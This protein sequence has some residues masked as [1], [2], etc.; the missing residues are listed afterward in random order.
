VSGGVPRL[1]RWV[2]G[3]DRLGTLS[4]FILAHVFTASPPRTQAPWH[5]S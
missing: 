2:A 5:P 4:A 3:A 1:R